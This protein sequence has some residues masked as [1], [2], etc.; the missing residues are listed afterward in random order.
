MSARF[1]MFFASPALLAI[2]TAVCSA[3]ES[4]PAGHSPQKS[5]VVWARSWEAAIREAGARNVPIMIMIVSP[6]D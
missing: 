5:H 1:T 6:T 4:D 3:Q 2:G